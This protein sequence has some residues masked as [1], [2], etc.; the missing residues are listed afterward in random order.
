[1]RPVPVAPRLLG[2]VLPAPVDGSG[3]AFGPRRPRQ[4]LVVD[5]DRN[6]RHAVRDALQDDGYLVVEAADGAEALRLLGGIEPCL[7]LLDMRMPGV[8]GWAF[9][10]AYRASDYPRVPLVVMTAAR[11]SRA[12][13]REIGADG[14]LDKPFDLDDLVRVLDKYCG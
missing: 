12:W 13:A 9:V 1:V 14:T 3:G 2:T 7:I 11:D 5:D 8:D 10:R 4:V 6:I